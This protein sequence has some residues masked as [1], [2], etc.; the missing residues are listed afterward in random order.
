[1]RPSR[2][3]FEMNEAQKDSLDDLQRKTGL[4]IRDLMNNGLSLVL[5]AV[6]ETLKGHEIAAVNEKQKTYRILVMPLLDSVIG[7]EQLKR[8]QAKSN[9][10]VG[11]S[12]A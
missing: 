11:A 6:N 7:R 9:E 10:V 4:S 8:E 1:M 2:V 12:T 5:W 3:T